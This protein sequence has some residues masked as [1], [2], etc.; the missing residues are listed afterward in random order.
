MLTLYKVMPVDRVVRCTGK[1]GAQQV[2]CA[3][4]DKS[5]TVTVEPDGLFSSHLYSR[6]KFG[7][8]QSD[9]L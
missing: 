1:P 9:P 5:L 2:S 7:A 4:K 3:V 8:E 6:W